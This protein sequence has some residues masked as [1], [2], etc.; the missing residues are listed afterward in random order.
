MFDNKP[1]TQPSITQS[2][3]IY[4]RNENTAPWTHIHKESM[5]QKSTNKSKRKSKRMRKAFLSSRCVY[6]RCGNLCNKI[7]VLI[8]KVERV[9]NIGK[10]RHRDEAKTLPFYI[11]ECA[12]YIRHWRLLPFY[13]LFSIC[14]FVFF[15]VQFYSSNEL[16]CTGASVYKVN[17]I[18]GFD[19]NGHLTRHQLKL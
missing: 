8:Q 12:E 7:S 5:K 11:C 13:S 6:L 3:S 17:S 14:L 16:N 2:L 9:A 1:K 4:R 15:S 10:Q 19:V 18:V